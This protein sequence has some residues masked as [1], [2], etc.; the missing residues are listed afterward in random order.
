MRGEIQPEHG[1]PGALQVPAG[2]GLGPGPPPRLR[3]G[4]GGAA[5]ERSRAGQPR[6]RAAE[7]AGGGANKGG[8]RRR[9]GPCEAV[10]P[11]PLPGLGLAGRGEA[12]RGGLRG[13]A[14]P[15]RSGAELR[16]QQ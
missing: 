13:P 5:P 16:P 1:G 9:C 14:P 11:L 7:A 3:A 12:R 4:S 8:G 2:P 10:R 15:A 6:L